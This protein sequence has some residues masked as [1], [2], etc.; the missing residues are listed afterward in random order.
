[1][2]DAPVQVP[3]VSA[4]QARKR[5][6]AL[7]M[8]Q[9]L[10]DR[11]SDDQAREVCEM[12]EGGAAD[13]YF[14]AHAE[15]FARVGTSKATFRAAAQ[16]A[17][18]SEIAPN[19]RDAVTSAMHK[20]NDNLVRK[21]AEVSDAA[22]SKGP[23]QPPDELAKLREHYAENRRSFEKFGMTL[24]KYEE[25]FN[26]AKK[27]NPALTFAEFCLMPGAERPRSSPVVTPMHSG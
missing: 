7:G 10:L 9:T 22:T 14:E 27:R 3:K 15:Q 17:G 25:S 4:I 21:F 6:L 23:A 1:M 20:D 26:H 24:A 11:L 5:L 12:L 18:L 2:A 8:P 13:A 16:A 19:M